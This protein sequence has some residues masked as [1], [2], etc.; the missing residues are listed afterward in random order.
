MQ[1]LLL[2]AAS[3]ACLLVWS[4]FSGRFVLILKD[5]GFN[6]QGAGSS[7]SNALISDFQCEIPSAAPAVLTLRGTQSWAEQRGFRVGDGS[8]VP[9]QVGGQADTEILDSWS[10][11]G[12]KRSPSPNS[13][14]T[15]LNHITLM[16]AARA[17]LS[18][19]GY[20]QLSLFSDSLS[21]SP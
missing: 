1:Q 11:S 8:V 7:Q 2:I 21:P 18:L 19:C 5:A 15:P 4:M 20:F 16:S 9:G 13:A 14:W 6:D 12:W 17:G 3:I 10:Y